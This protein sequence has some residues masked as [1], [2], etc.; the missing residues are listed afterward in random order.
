[1]II[2]GKCW[3]KFLL[4]ESPS[5]LTLNQMGY[6]LQTSIKILKKEQYKYFMKHV[7]NV[8][9]KFLVTMRWNVRIFDAEVLRI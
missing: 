2:L 1:M 3:N 6:I 5:A 4:R 7:K 8:T 9:F